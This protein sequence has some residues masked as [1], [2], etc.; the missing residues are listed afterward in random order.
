MRRKKNILILAAAA[1]CMLLCTGCVGQSAETLY[2]LPRQPDEYYELQSA[3]DQVLGTGA[4]YSGPLTGSNQQAVQLADLDGDA[5]DEAIVFAKVAGAK[6]LKAYIFDRGTDGAYENTA[7]IEGDGSAF[8]SADYVQIDGEPGLEIIVG[9][10]LSEQISQSLGAYAYREGRLVELMTANYAE[11]TAV[12]LDGD[13]CRDIFILRQEADDRTGTAELYRYDSGQMVREPEVSLSTGAK[14]IKRMVTGYVSSGVPA[15]FV[16]S[17]YSQ[18]EIVTDIFS[19]RNGSFRN[20]ST[21]AET[22]LSAQT[23]RNY[24]VYAADIDKDGLV[25]LPTPVALPSISALEETFWVI[26]W[27]NLGVDGQ[28]TIKMTTFHSYQNGW[29]LELPESWHDKMTVSRTVTDLDV[30]GYTFSKWNG[31]G[32]DPEE[33]FTIYAF[34][35]ENRLEQ[36]KA[37]G[38]FLLAEKGETAYAASFGDCPWADE[39]SEND[40]Q[41]MFHFIQ[42]D[43]NS[44]EI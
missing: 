28:R 34:S 36:A 41:A 10:Q 26:D 44:G 24:N 18:E 13:D 17:T 3:I 7:V 2:T 30:H 32:V 21:N 39:L 20:I 23:V 35:G 22:G 43:W 42:V 37:A 15:V 31:R 11:Y 14:E 38:C 12:D 29:Y 33:I 27:F 5:R 6:A 40:L 4:S 8:D 25:E 16:A 19:F 9:R 1:F